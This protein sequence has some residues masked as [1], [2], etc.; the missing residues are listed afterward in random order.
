M[1]RIKT[2]TLRWDPPADS[3]VVKYKIYVT[4]GDSADPYT[5]TMVEVTETQAILPDAFPEGTFDQEGN[6]VIQVT[7]IDD[8]G[9]E[10]DERVIIYPF[11]FHPPAPVENLEVV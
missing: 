4:Y 2:K 9:N 11:D 8:Q 3:D 5:G 1:A 6:Y 10:S 7:A